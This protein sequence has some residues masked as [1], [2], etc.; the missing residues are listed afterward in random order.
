M[1]SIAG[2]NSVCGHCGDNLSVSM[3]IQPMK[4]WAA[5]CHWQPWFPGK[6]GRW[7]FDS[8]IG[9]D[10]VYR[11]QAHRNSAFWLLYE[12]WCW[13]VGGVWTLHANLFFHYLFF[14][15]CAEQHSTTIQAA[16][17]AMDKNILPNLN[18]QRTCCRTRAH[19]GYLI[20][21]EWTRTSG[22]AWVDKGHLAELER[23]K[24]MLPNPSNRTPV[25]TNKDEHSTRSINSSIQTCHSRSCTLPNHIASVANCCTS[26]CYARK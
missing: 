3:T 5:R 24:E 26:I 9:S 14:F 16:H 21:P 4:V 19:N 20:E 11:F 15:Y 18:G 12:W 7:I 25:P 2:I 22:R 10:A 23:A 6:Q 1:A 17:G 13:S 8:A